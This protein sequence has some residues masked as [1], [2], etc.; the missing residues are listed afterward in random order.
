MNLYLAGD[1]ELRAELEA[2]ADTLE[3]AGHFI[4]SRWVRESQPVSTD[5]VDRFIEIQN[6]VEHISSEDSAR[7]ALHD[8]DDL[9][10]AEAMVLVNGPSTRG[11]KH[12]EL[13]AALAMDM[14]VYL[15]GPRTNIFHHHLLV[16]QVW[17][18]WD[19]AGREVLMAELG[20]GEDA[21]D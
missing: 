19:E 5:W 10:A 15:I 2:L 12:V 6:Q 11:G 7:I 20:C 16:T 17:P 21:E 9:S 4:T 14:P 3:A 18:E 13:G 8:L 1:Y